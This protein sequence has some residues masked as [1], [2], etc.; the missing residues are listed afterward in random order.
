MTLWKHNT[1]QS[2]VVQWYVTNS[3]SSSSSTNNSCLSQTTRCYFQRTPRAQRGD[4]FK[5]VKNALSYPTLVILNALEVLIDSG[6]YST[7]Y[8]NVVCKA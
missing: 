7:D 6:K 3:R 2:L 4:V 8:P 5:C 1:G